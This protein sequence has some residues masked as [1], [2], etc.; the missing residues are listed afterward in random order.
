MK[1]FIFHSVTLT[2]EW[3]LVLDVV[4]LFSAQRYEMIHTDSVSEH[5][6][7]FSIAYMV[8]KY[9]TFLYFSVFSLLDVQYSTPL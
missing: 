6:V 2:N 7:L 8:L 5:I 3:P 1:S 4:Y 9:S